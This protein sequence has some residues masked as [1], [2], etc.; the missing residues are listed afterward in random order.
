MPDE[1][2]PAFNDQYGA[3]V[4]DA[5]RDHVN[6][7]GLTGVALVERARDYAERGKPEFVLAYLAVAELP[8][9]E[10]RELLASAF[11]QR[12]NNSERKAAELDAEHHRPFPLIALEAR[13]DRQMARQIRQGKPIKPYARAARPLGTS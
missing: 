12:A 6:S 10:K 3:L 8:D 4:K 5:F 9:E 13:R 2:L 7:E 1:T 11:E